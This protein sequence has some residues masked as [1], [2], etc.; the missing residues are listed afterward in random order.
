MSNQQDPEFRKGSKASLFLELAE[1][2][3]LGFSRAVSVALTI[4]LP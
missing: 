3:E 1:P 2:D 4:P